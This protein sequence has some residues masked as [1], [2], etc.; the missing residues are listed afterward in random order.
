MERFLNCS[1]FIWFIYQCPREDSSKRSFSQMSKVLNI[2][3]I[4]GT[5]AVR[6]FYSESN[7]FAMKIKSSIL[8]RQMALGEVD[9][10]T[11]GINVQNSLTDKV[12]TDGI[13]IIIIIINRS[14][15]PVTIVADYWLSGADISCLHDQ[16]RT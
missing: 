3:H 11:L 16:F 9:N 1:G 13:I 6:I 2:N 4:K 7:L 15:N 8:C 14:R 5:T 12:N 10:V